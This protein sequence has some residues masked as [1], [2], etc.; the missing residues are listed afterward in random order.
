MNTLFYIFVNFAIALN[1]NYSEL[2]MR[3]IDEF[4]SFARKKVIESQ[5]AKSP[6]PLI[7]AMEIVLARPDT[8]DGIVRKTLPI[9]KQALDEQEAEERAFKEIA[10]R[11]IK[12][13]K[14]PK[15]VDKNKQI[16]YIVVLENMMSELKPRLKDETWVKEILVKIRDANIEL[17]A[18]AKKETRWRIMKDSNSPSDIAAKLVPKE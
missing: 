5:D 10:E 14:E 12:T 1:F 13:L 18:E 15:G 6:D 4:E 2:A 17:S 8:R 3:D 11:A 7:S 16:S 9:L